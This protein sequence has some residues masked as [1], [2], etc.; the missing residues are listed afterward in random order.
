MKM[1]DI[2]NEDNDVEEGRLKKSLKRKAKRAGKASGKRKK[3]GIGETSSS[4][5]MGAGSVA[6]TGNGFAT[7]GIGT[8][9]RAGVIAPKKPKKKSSK[10]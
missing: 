5:G 7:G 8:K 3:S 10:A 2:V 1:I 6:G 9:S 4:G